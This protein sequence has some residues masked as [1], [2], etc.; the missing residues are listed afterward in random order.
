[1]NKALFNERINE[2]WTQ[3]KTGKLPRAE[4]FVAIERLTDE[5]ITANGRRPDPAQLDRL[6]TLC[7]YE[8]VTDDNSYK[9]SHED[10]PI[11]SEVQRG[12]RYKREKTKK[13]VI[14]GRDKV[15][16]YKQT[17]CE[18]ENGEIRKVRQKIYDYNAKHP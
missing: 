1:M 8:E 12:R 16:G 10:E 2:L 14:T 18:T 15:I 11:L 5:Y 17:W 6:A 7:L 9:M 4:R 13:D 3:T